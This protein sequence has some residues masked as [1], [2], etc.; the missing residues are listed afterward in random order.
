MPRQNCCLRRN[1]LRP[2]GSIRSF[3]GICMFTPQSQSNAYPNT[4]ERCNT[5]HPFTHPDPPAHKSLPSPS[6]NNSKPVFAIWEHARSPPRRTLAR[7]APFSQVRNVV[8]KVSA[9]RT[10]LRTVFWLGVLREE[11][12]LHQ[13]DLKLLRWAVQALRRFRRQLMLI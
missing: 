6:D 1:G 10:I 2:R 4:P 5:I 13:L 3:H 11:C 7:L 9:Q 12:W 8:L